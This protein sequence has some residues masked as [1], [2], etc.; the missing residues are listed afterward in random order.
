MDVKEF[1]SKTITF[2][3]FFYAQKIRKPFFLAICI[4][5]ITHRLSAK[6]KGA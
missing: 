3:A 1:A 4:L 5:L 2:G 6:N